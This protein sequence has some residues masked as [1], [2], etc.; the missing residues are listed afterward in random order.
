MFLIGNNINP[1]TMLLFYDFFATNF[2]FF[3]YIPIIESINATPIDATSEAT[4]SHLSYVE[5]VEK[6]PCAAAAGEN[7]NNVIN[8]NCFASNVNFVQVPELEKDFSN[9]SDFLQK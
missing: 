1:Q 9:A 4:P 3:N 7:S 5:K 8:C 2:T 6:C